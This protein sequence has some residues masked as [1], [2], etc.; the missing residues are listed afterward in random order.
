M[1]GTEPEG[2]AF[3]W[4]NA[5]FWIGV[6]LSVDSVMYSTASALGE[7][8]AWILAGLFAIAPTSICLH[9]REDIHNG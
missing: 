1:I 8:Y 4:R 3:T 9:C 2:K 7:I 6:C 5:A